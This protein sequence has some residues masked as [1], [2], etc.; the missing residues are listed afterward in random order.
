MRD[1]AAAGKTIGIDLSAG[2]NQIQLS[3]AFNPEGAYPHVTWK[4]SN[5]KVATVDSNGLV[6]LRGKG[7]ATITATA[8]DGSGKKATVTINAAALVKEIII[9]GQNEIAA[10]MRVTLKATALPTNASSKS[11]TW[12]SSDKKIATVD[13]K[14]RVTAVK[15]L[16]ARSVVTITATAND[17]SG[18]SGSY[19][20]TV[21]P[22]A[23]KITLN[24]NDS[25][26]PNIIGYD[27]AN[28]VGMI[29]LSAAVAPADAYQAVTW[30]T[31]NK[32]VA[33][34]NSNGVVTVVGKGKATITASAKDGS[35]KKATVTI[36]SAVLVKKVSITGSAAVASGKRI[37]LKASVL[38]TNATSKS[39]TWTSSNKKIATVDS[40]GRV[41]GAK[42][43][44]APAM[45]TITANAKDGSG[46]YATYDVTVYP[47]VTRLTIM[48]DGKQ[49]PS[50]G[51]IVLA[52]QSEIDLSAVIQPTSAY[53]GVTWKS[54][55]TRYATVDNG[56]VT[57]L[58]KGK[59]TITATAQDGSGKKDSITIT[60]K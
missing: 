51:T 53:V 1:G 14:G 18:I 48:Y 44:T 42:K 30:K 55:N 58:K 22:L 8:K 60:I 2:V 40:A 5:K 11:V 20:V 49:A 41:T 26:A 34:V 15:K 47:A 50:K 16:T 4:T 37:T 31:S 21:Y 38:P 10:G 23:T 29:T 13:S 54:S 12:T 27:L 24:M 32:K 19:D 33:T 43:L 7:K 52:K 36:N 39:L 56:V 25:L 6:T 57:L 9:S 28:G 17:G 35:G 3:A 45:V 46:V 59:V